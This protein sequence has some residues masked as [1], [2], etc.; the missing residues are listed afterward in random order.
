MGIRSNAIHEFNYC[1]Y[2]VSAG[3]D[4]IETLAMADNFSVAE[5]A[6]E[7]SFLARP[8]STIELR[9]KGRVITT[10]KTGAY[11]SETKTVEILWRR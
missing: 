7:A 3:G 2:T 6:F 10:V 11:C 9:N 1:V 4:I 8:Q 5:A